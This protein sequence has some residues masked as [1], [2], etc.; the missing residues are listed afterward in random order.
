MKY[1]IRRKERRDDS[2]VSLQEIEG[3]SRC[4]LHVGSGGQL[5]RM[6]LSLQRYKYQISL[7][8]SIVVL[9][10]R[11]NRHR[12]ESRGCLHTQFVLQLKC[13]LFLDR[14]PRCS[15]RSCFSSPTRRRQRCS[16]SSLRK[17]KYRHRW[18]Q[19]RVSTFAF[20]FVF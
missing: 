15:P 7:Y 11:N 4:T 2:G 16:S 8:R 3:P 18:I 14:S 6:Q 19:I 13:F 9:L 10:V 17:R 1:E 5:S 20:M 12:N